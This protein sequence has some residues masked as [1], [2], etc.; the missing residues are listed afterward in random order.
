MNKIWHNGTAAMTDIPYNQRSVR[1]KPLR[2]CQQKQQLH[3]LSIRHHLERRFLLLFLFFV[4]VFLFFVFLFVFCLFFLFFFFVFFVCFFFF[5]V[6]FCLFC[7]FSA[8]R[9]NL[10]ENCLL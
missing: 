4:F 6:C 8:R 9:F 1:E 3:V 5:F 10:N 2:N 7:F